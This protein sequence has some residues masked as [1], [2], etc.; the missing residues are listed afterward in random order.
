MQGK[1]NLTGTLNN[2]LRVLTS[3][4]NCFTQIILLQILD[5][6]LALWSRL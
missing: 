4:T 3:E 5:A 2:Q 1:E 6:A